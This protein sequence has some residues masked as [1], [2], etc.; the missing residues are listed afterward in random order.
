ML[1]Y[2]GMITTGARIVSPVFLLL[3]LLPSTIGVG[4]MEQVK[5][6]KKAQR[7]EWK[8]AFAQAIPPALSKGE[9]VGFA[10]HGEKLLS[11]SPRPS[12][13]LAIGLVSS[14]NDRVVTQLW[15]SDSS[16][17]NPK[18]RVVEIPGLV[19][20]TEWSPDDAK[21]AYS[22]DL[23]PY[24]PEV[25]D[26]QLSVLDIASGK[27][28]LISQGGAWGPEWSANRK[29]LFFWQ[30]QQAPDGKW[31]PTRVDIAAR[32]EKREP[33]SPLAFDEPGAFSP[34]AERFAGL[35]EGRVIVEELAPHRRSEHNLPVALRQDEMLW[36]ADSKW[37]LVRGRPSAAFALSRMAYAI[38][39]ST[40]ALVSLSEKLSAI[41][42]ARADETVEVT[43][44]GWI[45]GKSPRLLV[46]AEHRKVEGCMGVLGA[47]PLSKRWLIYDLE[48]NVT[49]EVDGL[50]IPQFP[51][52]TQVTVSPD[53]GLVKVG[54]ELYSLSQ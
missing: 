38:N 12:H 33:V 29:T 20:L 30:R 50:G 16:G 49:T 6:V 35:A 28:T 42:R 21:L 27:T 32:P 46:L 25:S 15:T 47:P 52:V 41:E 7:V 1:T 2:R 45:P 5:A 19:R 53:G 8:Q 31:Q 24:S 37:L 34:R 9:Q 48:A 18:R 23:T 10:T 51:D 3:A 40:G 17:R 14:R 39:T 43:A 36:S 4:A 44:A 11:F 54:D 13:R 22:S 26:T